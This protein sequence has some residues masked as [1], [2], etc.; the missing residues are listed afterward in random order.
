M[1]IIDILLLKS[2]NL[3]WFSKNDFVDVT[4]LPKV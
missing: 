1:R 3:I 4:F 2:G